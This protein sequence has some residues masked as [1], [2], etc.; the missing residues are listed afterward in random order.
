M[1]IPLL[2]TPES[3]RSFSVVCWA[4]RTNWEKITEH[5]PVTR[6]QSILQV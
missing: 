4:A 6:R 2:R 5:I 3:F 1:G